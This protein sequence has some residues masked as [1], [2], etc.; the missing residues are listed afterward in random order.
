MS[1]SSAAY[2]TASSI[3]TRSKVIAFLPVPSRVLIGIGLAEVA[4]GQLVHAVV[5]DAAVLGVADQHRVIDRYFQC[6]GFAGLFGEAL[7]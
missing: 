5:V 1:A 6:C 3:G 2:F 4:F 7:Q